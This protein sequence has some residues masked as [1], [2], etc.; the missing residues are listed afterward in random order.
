MNVPADVLIRKAGQWLDHAGEDL[1]LARHALKLRSSC[2]YRLIA[3]HAQQCA[4]KSLKAFLVFQE[5]DF[6]YTHDLF[7]LVRLCSGGISWAATAEEAAA[8]TPYAAAA[9]YPGGWLE[10]TRGEAATAVEIA[11]RLRTLIHDDIVRR[12]RERHGKAGLAI[13]GHGAK[14]RSRMDD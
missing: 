14:T 10:V 4:E 9:R 12:I 3:Y 5:I 6:P 13:F 7:R 2:P 8:L 11:A 1:V